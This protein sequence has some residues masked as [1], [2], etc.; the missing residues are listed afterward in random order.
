MR[1]FRTLAL[2]V[3]VVGL[4][5]GGGLLL[6][7]A[8]RVSGWSAA[9]PAIAGVGCLVMAAA[10][11]GPRLAALITYPFGVLLGHV[12]YPA[13]QFTAPPKSLLLSLR[14]RIAEGRFRSV[15]QQ[16][17]GLLK[18]YPHDG[19]LYQVWALLEAARGRGV[20]EVTEAA[21]RGLS[22]AAFTD[23][24]ALVLA[25]P[26]NISAR[27]RVHGADRYGRREPR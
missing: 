22:K 23:Y 18:A 5:V 24:Q 14:R 2:A 19:G 3:I 7:K 12:F 27:G 21:E 4:L 15:E 9:S 13:S 25:L 6:T 1:L 8:A 10:F 26:K 16:L 17:S 20:A 11:A